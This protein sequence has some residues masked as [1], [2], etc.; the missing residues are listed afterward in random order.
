MIFALNLL[1][2]QPT[3]FM[4]DPWMTGQADLNNYIKSQIVGA[5]IVASDA[6]WNEL[7]SLEI[8]PRCRLTTCDLLFLCTLWIFGATAQRQ[9]V[10]EGEAKRFSPADSP[11][12]DKQSPR[13]LFSRRRCSR[14]GGKLFLRPK[15]ACGRHGACTHMHTQHVYPS[16]LNSLII[17][18]ELMCWML[19]IPSEVWTNQLIQH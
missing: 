2:I 16:T 8:F 13:L 5:L 6:K 1:Q 10:S 17:H 14:L 4:F 15:F 7:G 11:C 19:H 9:G 3:G 18:P 12:V